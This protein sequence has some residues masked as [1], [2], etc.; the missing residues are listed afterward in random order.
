MKLSRCSGTLIV[1]YEVDKTAGEQQSTSEIQHLCLDSYHGMTSNPNSDWRVY[2]TNAEKYDAIY[3]NITIK[4]V[5]LLRFANR[6]FMCSNGNRCLNYV[7]SAKSKLVHD[8]INLV[9]MGMERNLFLMNNSIRESTKFNLLFATVSR[10]SSPQLKLKRH[11]NPGKAK[12]RI[13]VWNFLDITLTT[14]LTHRIERIKNARR[15]SE[16]HKGRISIWFC[17][18]IKAAVKTLTQRIT[19]MVS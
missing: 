4:R 3:C 5:F 10:I 2:W 1:P 12:Q 19:R 6:I 8:G 14:D 17:A 7:H 16:K 11:R 13:D 9:D 18:T 15:E